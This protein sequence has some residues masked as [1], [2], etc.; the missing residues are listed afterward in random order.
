MYLDFFGW[1]QLKYFE[2]TD[3]WQK[4]KIYMIILCSLKTLLENSMMSMVKSFS[5][6]AYKIDPEFGEFWQI[7]Y[8]EFLE[9][10]RLY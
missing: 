7:I 2:E 8:D 6:T 10:K 5:A 1:A 9:T 4:H 3:Q